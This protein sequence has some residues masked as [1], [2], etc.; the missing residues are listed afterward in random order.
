MYAV[1]LV[2]IQMCNVQTGLLTYCR[3]HSQVSEKHAQEG[4][5]AKKKTN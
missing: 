3:L 5:V 2:I 4:G 1:S